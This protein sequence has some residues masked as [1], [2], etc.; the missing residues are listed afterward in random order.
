MLEDTPPGMEPE[1]GWEMN[2]PA[3]RRDPPQRWAQRFPNRGPRP[4]WPPNPAWQ[5]SFRLIRFFF[6]ICIFPQ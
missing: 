3:N 1:L 2:P 4:A 5:A 6:S